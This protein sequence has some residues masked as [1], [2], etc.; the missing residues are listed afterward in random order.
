[1]Y[2]FVSFTVTYTSLFFK[3]NVEFK[4]YTGVGKYWVSFLKLNVINIVSPQTNETEVKTVGE[5][6]GVCSGGV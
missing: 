1:M 2:I 6:G 5:E 3:N 4:C